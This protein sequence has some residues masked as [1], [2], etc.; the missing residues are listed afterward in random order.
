MLARRDY[1]ALAMLNVSA[2]QELAR[3]VAALEAENMALKARTAQA[4]AA[5]AADKAQTTAT[6]ESLAQRLR[7]LEAGGG[8]AR[9]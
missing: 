8:Q 6:L 4:A 3:K 5:A 7:A 9:R 1:D 2:T